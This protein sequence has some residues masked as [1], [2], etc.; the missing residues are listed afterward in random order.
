[1]R[2]QLQTLDLLQSGL[3]LCLHVRESIATV[4]S[5][6]VVAAAVAVRL[7]RML[8]L[9]GRLKLVFLSSVGRWRSASGGCCE[10]LLLHRECVANV[11]N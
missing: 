8:L 7:W 9:V 4:V 3:Q 1:L 6:G 10:W 2:L 5:V 11:C